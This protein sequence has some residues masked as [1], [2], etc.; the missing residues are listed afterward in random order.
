MNAQNEKIENLQKEISQEIN[1]I[2]AIKDK[3]EERKKRGKIK[4]PFTLTRLDYSTDF[5]INVSLEMIVSYTNPVVAYKF[6]PSTNKIAFGTSDS[7][8]I[9]SIPLITTP[10]KITFLSPD[11]KLKDFAVVAQCYAII[12]QFS[13]GD[14]RPLILRDGMWGPPLLNSNERVIIKASNSALMIQYYPNNVYL[15]NTTLEQR[16]NNTVGDAPITAAELSPNGPYALFMTA[17]NEVLLFSFRKF[18]VEK[19]INVTFTSAVFSNNALNLALLRDTNIISFSLPEM[20]V[21][22]IVNTNS[23]GIAIDHNFVLSI[24][25]LPNTDGIF[26]III[27][28]TTTMKRVAMLQ[29]DDDEIVQLETSSKHDQLQLGFRLKSG[30]IAVFYFRSSR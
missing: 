30:R 23:R 3:I 6:I 5:S 15:A 14:I 1:N 7:I 10:N 16:F 28:D 26:G 20:T 27:Y 19:K 18:N 29:I 8:T 21:N 25:A 24:E 11:E 4:N 17:K 12:A 22:G 9:F 13:T 2:N